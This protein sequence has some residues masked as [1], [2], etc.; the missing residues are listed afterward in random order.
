MKLRRELK[1]GIAF[2]IA[3]IVVLAAICVLP[4]ENLVCVRP[5]YR[6]YIIDWTYLY[7]HRLAL[8]SFLLLLLTVL[9]A[10]ILGMTD[11]LKGTM[12]VQALFFVVAHYLY[13]Y[14]LDQVS[15]FS[16][17][18]FVYYVNGVPHLDLGQLVLTL[19]IIY[20]VRHGAR[21]FRSRLQTSYRAR[22]R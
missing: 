17:S 10:Y 16:F 14:K 18:V 11:F 1:Y 7:L 22:S 6:S 21:S 13:L 3:S 5:N 19:L 15:R 9:V 2:G 8:F 20:A 4:L 12:I